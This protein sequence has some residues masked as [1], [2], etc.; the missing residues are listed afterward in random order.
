L[1]TNIYVDGFNL[2]YGCLRDTP[3]RWLDLRSF[4][5]RLLA[6]HHIVF[7]I[8]YFTARARPTP[9]DPQ[10]PARQ[11]LY[12]RALR[13][14]PDLSIHEGR[15]LSHPKWMPMYFGD[16]S[17][18]PGP[19]LRPVPTEARVRVTSPDAAGVIWRPLD[20]PGPD[21]QLALRQHPRYTRILKFEEKGSDVNLA[22]HLLYDAFQKD[23]DCAVVVSN[24][25]DLTE[26]IHVVRK[27]LGLVVGVINPHPKP[28]F[29]LKQV[30]TFLLP[31]TEDALSQSQFPEVLSDR[32][33]KQIR[34]PRAW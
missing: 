13:T 17:E 10:V 26:P 29:Q 14:L 34:K 22:T 32:K 25:S 23:F 7:R 33:G 11:D 16:D 27:K 20:E 3:Y 18:R 28:S 9:A 2:Y 30:A 15:F 4:C 19:P 8:R 5:Q 1:R 31:V 12:L 24:D 21:G 6:P